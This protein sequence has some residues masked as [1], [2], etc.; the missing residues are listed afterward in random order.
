MESNHADSF[1]L[2]YR[3]DFCL[4]LIIMKSKS[5]QWN[6]DL[7]MARHEKLKSYCNSCRGV[8]ESVD[9]IIIVAS[10]AFHQIFHFSGGT[11]GKVSR[12]HSGWHF[13]TV[14]PTLSDTSVWNR[15]LIARLKTYSKKSFFMIWVNWP[16]KPFSRIIKPKVRSCDVSS[17]LP[18]HFTSTASL[19]GQS[20]SVYWT[21]TYF[22]FFS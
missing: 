5:L 11:T 10:I 21:F 16:F 17:N 2:I 18:N 6:L 15:A 20:W 1:G 8:D 19:V 22:L 12:I 4:H 14:Y 13:M 7:M 9:Q 3:S